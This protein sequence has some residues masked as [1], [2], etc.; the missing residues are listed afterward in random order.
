[1][2]INQAAG[3]ADPTNGAPINF[4]VVFS[5]NVTDFATGDVTLG[6]TAEPTNAAVTGGGTTYNVAV[7]GMGDSGTVIASIP[8]G[9][10]HDAAGDANAASTSTDNSVNYE[11]PTLVVLYEFN[12]GVHDGQVVVT[13][14]TASEANTLGFR[15]YR[16]VGGQ[17][18]QVGRFIP[19]QGWPNGGIG[20]TYEVVDADAAPGR[21]YRYKLVE[22]ETDGGTQEY[23]PFEREAFELRLTSPVAF[24]ADGAVIRWLSR[25]NEF[26]R[27][28]RSLDLRA[29]FGVRA[30]SIPATPPQNVYTDDVRDVFQVF[31][32]IEVER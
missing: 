26:Y 23:G 11:A 31:Y 28:M 17:W 24:T 2:T 27:L 32:R 30:A 19:A 20:A 9:V 7:S 29:G 12:V 16:L 5:E 3:Q 1:V 10:A 25:S 22:I 13:W 8:A 4:T 14:A 15:L 6:G 18:A 21:T